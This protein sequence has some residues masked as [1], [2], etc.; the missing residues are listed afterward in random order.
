MKNSPCLTLVGAGPGDEELI[1]LKGIRA[2]ETA[3]V[4]LYDAL[5]NP[6]LL[7]YA[8]ATAERIFVGKRAGQHLFQQRQIN[9]MIVRYA[10]QYGHVVRLKGGDPFVFGRG[11]EEQ[12]YALRHGL[13]VSVVPGI[14]CALAVPA[15]H[16]IPLTHRGASESFWVVTGTTKDERLPNDMLLAAQSSA[17]VVILMGTKRLAEIVSLFTHHRGG[18][19]PIAIIQNGTR[20]D[21]QRV[22][23]RLNTIVEMVAQQSVGAPAVIV[24]G[25]VV[26]HRL[27]DIRRQMANASNTNIIKE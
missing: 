21:E 5:A 14:S 11:Q 27:D 3:D 12:E 1:T 26:E 23:G 6:A 8:P 24:I 9:Q 19:E 15:L 13:E 4:V 25:E 22:V 18:D 20:P 10:H 2:L 7:Q 17:T 16:N